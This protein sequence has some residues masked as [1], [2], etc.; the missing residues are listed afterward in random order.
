MKILA[1][2]TSNQ[3]GNPSVHTYEI[4]KGGGILEKGGK[5]TVTYFS[6]ANGPTPARARPSPSVPTVDFKS[7]HTNLR[8][9]IA[10]GG[11]CSSTL[12]IL[13]EGIG[14]PKIC[15]IQLLGRAKFKGH[16]DD[17][18]FVLE[19]KGITNPHMKTR[20]EAMQKFL[21]GIGDSPD[22]NIELI[23]Y[24]ARQIYGIEFALDISQCSTRTRTP[25]GNRD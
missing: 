5:I 22:S 25:I 12:P 11:G 18:S 10:V 17:R 19:S 3:V 2:R 24:D 13:S 6:D 1:N 20:N 21:K 23:Q 14:I 7:T 16:F 15:E 8:A 4:V 9:G